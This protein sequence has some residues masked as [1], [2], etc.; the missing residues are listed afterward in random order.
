MGCPIGFPLPL[1]D[2]VTTSVVLQLAPHHH[3]GFV[4]IRLHTPQQTLILLTSSGLFISL[5][6]ATHNGMQ[7]VLPTCSNPTIHPLWWNVPQCCKAFHAY[8]CSNHPHAHAQTGNTALYSRQTTSNQNEACP[9][10]AFILC[11]ELNI[12]CFEFIC[13]GI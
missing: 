6:T 4:C 8:I 9:I 7:L 11:I 1:N 13:C 5:S 2:L 3:N 12:I 10:Q